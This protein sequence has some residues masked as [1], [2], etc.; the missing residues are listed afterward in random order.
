MSELTRK[1]VRVLETNPVAVEVERST[2]LSILCFRI[3]CFS[4]IRDFVT[5]MSFLMVLSSSSTS[6]CSDSL[7]IYSEKLSNL[8]DPFLLPKKY[9]YF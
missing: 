2:S 9:L 6:D 3:K 5:L 8:F 1:S 4:S 7:K